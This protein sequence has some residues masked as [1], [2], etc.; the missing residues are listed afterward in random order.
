MMARGWGRILYIQ[1]IYSNAITFTPLD[2]RALRSLVISTKLDAA[3]PLRRARDPAAVAINNSRRRHPPPRALPGS[4][5]VKPLHRVHAALY[6]R[7]HSGSL[8]VL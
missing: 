8:G 3:Y 1:C 2:W 7:E 4:R 5:A 6:P